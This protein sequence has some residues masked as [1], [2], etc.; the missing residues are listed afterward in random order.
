MF[1]HIF[2]Q[3]LAPRSLHYPPNNPD[4]PPKNFSLK[5]PLGGRTYAVPETR[6]DQR[7]LALASSLLY[8]GKASQRCVTDDPSAPMHY[9]APWRTA[10]QQSTVP[11]STSTFYSAPQHFNNLQCPAALQQ[12]TV[13]HCTS[14]VQPTSRSPNPSS[15]AHRHPAVSFLPTLVEC[16]RTIVIRCP[17]HHSLSIG[18]LNT[19]APICAQRTTATDRCFF[20]P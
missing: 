13:L 8:R 15:H 6:Q 3:N 10:L 17:P 4:Q 18:C 11:H 12:S 16:P 19:I 2:C 7:H 1:C 20:S 14:T 5:G 9:S